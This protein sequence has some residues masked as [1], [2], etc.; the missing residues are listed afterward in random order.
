MDKVLRIRRAGEIGGQV[1]RFFSLALTCALINALLGLGT[2]V[3]FPTLLAGFFLVCALCV[4]LCAFALLARFILFR[5]PLRN[6][7]GWF[8]ILFLADFALTEWG[9][10]DTALPETLTCFF[11]LWK[12]TIAA[13]WLC[14]WP[15]QSFILEHAEGNT[16]RGSS[17]D[18]EYNERGFPFLHKGRGGFREGLGKSYATSEAVRVKNSSGGTRRL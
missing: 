12:L 8:L 5:A 6:L 2:S 4:L 1:E 3:D 11:H 7:W 17:P 10:G 16:T 18:F 13:R 9:G 14:L 15:I